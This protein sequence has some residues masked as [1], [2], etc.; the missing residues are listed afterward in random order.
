MVDE[1]NARA[2]NRDGFILVS[3]RMIASCETLRSQLFTGGIYI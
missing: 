2:E 1:V 3:D